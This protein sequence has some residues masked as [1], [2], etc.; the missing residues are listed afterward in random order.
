MHTDADK[1]QKFQKPATG[2]SRRH[3][4]NLAGST[5][6]ASLA[7]DLCAQSASE[8]SPATFDQTPLCVVKPEQTEGPYFVDGKLLRA[9]IRADPADAT[10]R[11]GLPLQLTL[12]LSALS[13]NTCGPLAGAVVDIWHNDALGEYSDV[14]DRRYDNRGKQFLRGYQLT[15]INGVVT[16][17]TIY[18]GWYPGRT[19][20]MHFKVRTDPAAERGSE[21]TS[22]LYF[23]DAVTDQVHQRAP[24]AANGQRSTRNSN[25][26]IFRRGGSELMLQLRRE[27][28]GFAGTFELGLEVG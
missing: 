14:R 5:A 18:P 1:F 7:A 21:F 15:D 6:A 8:D 16:F 28:E 9:D 17:T 3:L 20:H 2:F 22:Q 25:D 4:L 23:D 26:R 12:R 11:P 19:V 13:A 24:Y 10:F 27:G